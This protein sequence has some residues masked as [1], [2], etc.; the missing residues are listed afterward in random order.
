MWSSTGLFWSSVW[1]GVVI[2]KYKPWKGWDSI[3]EDLELLAPV[4][5]AL[6]WLSD[7]LSGSLWE[8]PA[9]STGLAKKFVWIFPYELFGQPNTTP[10][11]QRLKRL[12][13]VRGTWVQS[14]GR[15]DPLEKEVATHSSTLAGKSHGR[16]SAVDYSPWGRRE[17]DRTEQL[18]VTS[19]LHWRVIGTQ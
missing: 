10:V 9:L 18:H 4:K 2:R 1:F 3:L 19:I 17:S 6:Q 13:T 15:E 14:L 8:F 16:R 7:C 11:A 5:G 12:P